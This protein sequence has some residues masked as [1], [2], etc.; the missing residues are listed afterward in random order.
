MEAFYNNISQPRVDTVVKT[1]VVVPEGTSKQHV[2]W[3]LVDTRSDRRGS[4]SLT[5]MIH[6]PLPNNSVPG[7]ETV[8]CLE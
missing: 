3:M 2:E 8:G 6:I 1:L 7:S 5:P 4:P